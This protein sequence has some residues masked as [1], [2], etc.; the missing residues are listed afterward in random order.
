M[1]FK[2]G[3][4]QRQSPLGMFWANS[5]L[6]WPVTKLPESQEVPYMGKVN[7]MR[8]ADKE[9]DVVTIQSTDTW[10]KQKGSFKAC[11]SAFC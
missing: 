9:V 5:A 1:Q 3:T 7:K 8:E 10:A 11:A 6:S 2:G 4:S